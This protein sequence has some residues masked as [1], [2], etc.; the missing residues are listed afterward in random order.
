MTNRVGFVLIRPPT[1]WEHRFLCQS[2]KNF[3]FEK[4]DLVN[5]KENGQVEKRSQLRRGKNILKK[6]KIHSNIK[7]A[8]S[9]YDIV[10]AS[11]ARKEILIKNIFHLINLLKV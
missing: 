7:S 4:L 9:N 1:S 8:V 10:Y 11:S 5:P 3:G 6:T 2:F